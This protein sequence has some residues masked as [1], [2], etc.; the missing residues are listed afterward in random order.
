MELS[1]LTAPP[2]NQRS[3]IPDE[4]PAVLEILVNEISCAGMHSH[5]SQE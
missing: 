5:V 4:Q 1:F 3:L 2:G